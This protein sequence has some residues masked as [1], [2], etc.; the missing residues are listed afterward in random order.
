[1][2]NWLKELVEIRTNYLERKA[3]L[4]TCQSCETLKLEMERL[5]I[6]NKEL[7]NRILNP[8]VDNS[9]KQVMEEPRQLPKHNLPWNARRQLLEAEDR[10]KAK[11][12]KQNTI[13]TEELEKELD[14]VIQAREDKEH[15]I[16]RSNE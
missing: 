15:A 7:L 8:I 3:E 4:N 10:A 5:R 2:F 14:I 11:L 6:E 1:M 13:S 9:A 12:M 16:K